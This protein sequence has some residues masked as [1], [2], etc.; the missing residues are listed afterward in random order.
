MSVYTPITLPQV[1]Q[2][3]DHYKLGTILA[4]EGI[5]EGI[6]NTN[7]RITTTIGQYIL[8]IFEQFKADDLSYFLNL[9]DFLRRQGLSVPEPIKDTKQKTLMS[10]QSKPAVLFSCL[11]GHSLEHPK[12]AHCQQIGQTLGQLHVIGQAFPVTQANERGMSW[13]QKTGTKLLQKQQKSQTSEESNNLTND[14][15]Q[16]LA[17]ELKFQQLHYREQ[18]PMGVIHADLFRDNVLF[19]NDRLSAIVDFYT[20]GHGPLLFDLAITVNDWC[21]GN[22]HVLDPARAKA[23]IDAYGQQRPLQAKEKQ[24]WFVM[25]RA[26]ALRFWLSRLMY[27]QTNKTAQLSLDKDPDVLKCLLIKHRENKSLCLSLTS[28]SL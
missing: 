17:D 1:K 28:S 4:H 6:E 24:L 14:D 25:L 5:S 7:Y 11:P 3:V 10:W 19:E 22:N 15:A 8:T 23:L 20:A 12:L 13:V 27:R 9:L 16:L 26:A 2:L 18:L 21:I